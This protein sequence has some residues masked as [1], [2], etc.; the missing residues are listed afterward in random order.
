MN[1]LA[2]ALSDNVFWLANMLFT[3]SV[4]KKIMFNKYTLT[5][6]R[7]ISNIIQL[8][9]EILSTKPIASKGR[10]HTISNLSAVKARPFA[11]ASVLYLKWSCHVGSPNN[12]KYVV[13]PI[14]ILLFNSNTINWFWNGSWLKS[15][16]KNTVS[17]KV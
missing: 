16:T 8:S 13:F 14:Q 15:S 7:C 12:S 10:C 17:K 6:F 4:V 2:Q 9:C 3:I 1:C 5:Y 11:W